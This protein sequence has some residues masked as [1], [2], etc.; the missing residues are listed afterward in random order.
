[1]QAMAG[2]FV[3]GLVEVG[4]VG[5]FVGGFVGG[6]VGNFVGGGVGGFVGGLVGDFVGGLVGGFVGGLVGGFVGGLVGSFV[7]GRVGGFVGGLVGSFVGSRVGGFVGTLVG[8]F[9]GE[10]RQTAKDP[11]VRLQVPKSI[12]QK[13][14]C[15]Q[16]S[17]GTHRCCQAPPRC[18]PPSKRQAC[19]SRSRQGCHQPPECSTLSQSPEP[20]PN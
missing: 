1:V 7:G 9:V 11:S 18:C 3:G 12:T 15:L 6:F 13:W 8:V 5:S 16:D 10:P 17:R 14:V 2:A 20:M 19:T 4:E